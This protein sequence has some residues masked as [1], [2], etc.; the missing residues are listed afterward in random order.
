MRKET[1]MRRFIKCHDIG[2]GLVIILNPDDISRIEEKFHGCSVYLREVADDF[3]K[4]RHQ[5][6]I[7]VEEDIDYF[8][9]KLA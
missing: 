2:E 3:D 5:V 1:E 9:A 6:A 4:T 7:Q 8:L